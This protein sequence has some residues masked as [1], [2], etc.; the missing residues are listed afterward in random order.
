M[1]SRFAAESLAA[2]LWQPAAHDS[3]QQ[4]WSQV[5]PPS[6]HH[7]YFA[8]ESY[9][10]PLQVQH[11]A[12]PP[13]CCRSNLRC[14]C[15]NCS[16]LA[17]LA[18]ARVNSKAF[19]VSCNEHESVAIFARDAREIVPPALSPVTGVLTTPK[20]VATEVAGASAQ[21]GAGALAWQSE[22]MICLRTTGGAHEYTPK[23]LAKTGGLTSLAEETLKLGMS[24]P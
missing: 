11:Q 4:V 16:A 7:H 15:A 6:S 23:G 9:D 1:N 20:G 5:L 18:R 2:A 24:W 12:C 14:I 19:S 8:A 13:C 10:A 17:D 3:P 22:G 21:V